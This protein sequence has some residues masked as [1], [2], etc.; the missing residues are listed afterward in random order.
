[1]NPDLCSYLYLSQRNKDD[2]FFCV[3][4]ENM[5]TLLETLMAQEKVN[6]N[7]QLADQSGA[8]ESHCVDSMELKE[9]NSAKHRLI[10]TYLKI[11]YMECKSR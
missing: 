8:L 11:S 1:M 5:W 10:C 4:H 9:I 2:P 7:I 6:G 3:D